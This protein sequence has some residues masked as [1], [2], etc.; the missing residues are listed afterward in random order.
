M[1]HGYLALWL[2]L[3]STI[4]RDTNSTAVAVLS[5]AEAVHKLDSDR[6]H[7][8]YVS[9]LAQ[10]FA[11]LKAHYTYLEEELPPIAAVVFES[12][13]VGNRSCLNQASGLLLRVMQYLLRAV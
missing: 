6:C 4:V 2:L 5:G 1:V 12:W 9:L 13:I 7:W 8:V 3:Q 11:Y 10:G